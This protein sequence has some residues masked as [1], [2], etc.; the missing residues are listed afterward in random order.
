VRVQVQALR[1]VFG[2]RQLRRLELAWLATS[3]GIWGGALAL[4]VY[5]YAR[6]GP[7]TVGGVALLR[8][9]PGAAVGPFLALLAD[10]VSR[11]AIM[12]NRVRR[13]DDRAEPCPAL[14]A[15]LIA[16]RVRAPARRARQLQRRPQP[17]QNFRRRR[18]LPAAA[19]ARGHLRSV[20]R[21]AGGGENLQRLLR[22]PRAQSSVPPGIC[23]DDS[24]RLPDSGYWAIAP[25]CR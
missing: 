23:T 10:R 11:R 17:A 9:L 22:W 5:A 6:G 25:S 3:I 1:E 14:D 2:N 20:D 13:E 7:T 16:F 24:I 21:I 4:S 8:T 12:L 18:I 15:E 19:V